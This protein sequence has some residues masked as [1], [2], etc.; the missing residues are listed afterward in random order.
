MVGCQSAGL[1]I[2]RLLRAAGW[3]AHAGA[4]LQLAFGISVRYERR[5]VVVWLGAPPHAAR[6]GIALTPRMALPFYSAIRPFLRF[7][8]FDFAGMRLRVWLNVFKPHPSTVQLVE[9][10]RSFCTTAPQTALDVGTGAGGI[11]IA[12]ARAW[13]VA[14]VIGIDRS[15]RAVACAR[16]NAQ[17]LRCSNARFQLGDLLN[18]IPPASAQLIA[19]NVAWL[20]PA[21]YLSYGGDQQEFR[22]PPSALLDEHADGMGHLRRLIHQ[23]ATRLTP[24]GWIVLQLSALQ[25]APTRSL[26]EQHGFRIT[27]VADDMIAGRLGSA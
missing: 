11:A 9:A 27:E 24:G 21:V 6:G 23:A 1:T 8:E 12:L 18:E 25:L 3:R 22:G 17:R 19:G 16:M 20:A 10:A 2:H 15:A 26:L 5:G 4:A 14:R 13:P 7:G